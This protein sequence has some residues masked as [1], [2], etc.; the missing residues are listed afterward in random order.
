MTTVDGKI[1]G[2]EQ[3]E[4]YFIMGNKIFTNPD[5][6]FVTDIRSTG[7]VNME[8]AKKRYHLQPVDNLPLPTDPALAIL[9]THAGREGIC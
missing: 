3:G 9:Y 6:I 2:L 7:M 5:G 1:D 8:H 4:K